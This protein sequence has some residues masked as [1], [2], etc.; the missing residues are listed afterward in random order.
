MS[1]PAWE[2]CAGALRDL[3]A[4]APVGLA[5][6][7][8]QAAGELEQLR[9]SATAAEEQAAK[10]RFIKENGTDISFDREVCWRPHSATRDIYTTSCNPFELDYF[11]E[12]AMKE[13]TP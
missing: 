6:L 7:M 1:A 3:A 9:L 4:H 2:D 8:L 5:P 10:Y 11:L 13:P 12:A